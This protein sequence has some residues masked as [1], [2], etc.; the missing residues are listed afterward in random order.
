MVLRLEILIAIPYVGRLVCNSVDGGYTIEIH[1]QNHSYLNW[2]GPVVQL[3]KEQTRAL[4]GLVHLIVLV[5]NRTDIKL[6]N[7]WFFH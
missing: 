7:R 1:T 2:I 3:V 6:V 5:S 4:V